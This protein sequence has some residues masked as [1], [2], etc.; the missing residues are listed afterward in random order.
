ME[1]R[2]AACAVRGAPLAC[3]AQQRAESMTK[4]DSDVHLVD[5]RRLANKIIGGCSFVRLGDI[6]RETVESWL[7]GVRQGMCRDKKRERLAMIYHRK[8]EPLV[9]I[10]GNAPGT[11]WDNRQQ[12]YRRFAKFAA[13]CAKRYPSVRYWE[14]WNEM[15]VSFTQTFLEQGVRL[16]PFSAD[17]ATYKC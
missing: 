5:T 3:L 13:F 1:C 16:T 4:G 7:P 6:R 15:D 2:I 17:V 9:I 14:L 11:G 12:S 10:H 8:M